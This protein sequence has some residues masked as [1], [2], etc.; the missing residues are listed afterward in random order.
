MNLYYLVSC[1]I[2]A[3]QHVLARTARYRF[4]ISIPPFDCVETIVCIVK[5]FPPL[6]MAINLV[7]Y[8]TDIYEILT[9]RGPLTQ[10]DFENVQFSAS[11]ETLNN[12]SGRQSTTLDC[13]RTP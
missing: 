2:I 9:G 12:G 13:H 3:R 1:F 7:P 11:L 4:I 6:G 8:T 5:L 10:V